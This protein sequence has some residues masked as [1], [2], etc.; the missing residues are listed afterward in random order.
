[1]WSNRPSLK[2][3]NWAVICC[4]VLLLGNAA[5][6]QSIILH[7]RNGDRIAGTILSENTNQV[8]LST[9]WIKELVVPVAQ[10]ESREIPPA[11]QIVATKPA[12]PTATNPVPAT[13]IV[14]AAKPVVSVTPAAATPPKTAWLKRWKG[15]VAVGSDMIRGATDSQLYFGHINLTYAQPYNRDPKQFFRNTL[16]YNAEYGKTDGVLSANRMDGSSKTDLDVGRSVFVYNLG[17][18]GYDMIRKINL[19]YEDGPGAGYHLFTL[20]NFVMNVELGANYQVQER[21]DNTITRSFYYRL[22][23]DFTWK[24]NKQ[25]TMTEKF[26]FFPRAGEPSQYRAHFESTL[27][28][29][30]LSHLSINLT[31]LDFYDTNPAAGV[32]PN[33][34]ELRSSLGLKF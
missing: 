15:D 5:R 17:R 25:M 16:T 10:I 19:E 20:T 7:L 23:E 21:S 18:A 8:T 9:V 34:F 31:A 27:S 26:E 22:A 28:Y 11:P 29:A 4:A 13:N 1:M 6:A 3:F 2:L 24:V 12:P 33:S 14:V 30:L 32:P